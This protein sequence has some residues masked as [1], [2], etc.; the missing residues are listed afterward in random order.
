MQCFVCGGEMRVVTVE[1]HHAID[2]HGFEY[3]TFQ[4][5][6]CGDTER[7]LAFDA[8]QPPAAIILAPEPSEDLQDSKSKSILA[9]LV[10]LRTNRSEPR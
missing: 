8:T 4:C 1:P 2:M 9:R 7:R 3:R 5:V 6:S 10:R